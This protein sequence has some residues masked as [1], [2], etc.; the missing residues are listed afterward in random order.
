MSE[1]TTTTQEAPPAEPVV[2]PAPAPVAQTE[3]PSAVTQPGGGEAPHSPPPGAPSD[4]KAE[5]LAALK[6][7][8]AEYEAKAS[9]GKSAKERHEALAADVA[10]MRADQEAI[11]SK[12]EA[13]R[14]DLLINHLP[15]LGVPVDMAEVIAGAIGDVDLNSPAGRE[16]IQKWMEAHPSVTARATPAEKVAVLSEDDWDRLDKSPFV[17]MKDVREKLASIHSG[18]G[19]R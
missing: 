12:L 11:R 9:D 6:A 2:T 1:E 17:D 10:K 13:A 15:T 8:L 16:K 19:R 7:K 14:R 4:P 5:E 18:G 3:P